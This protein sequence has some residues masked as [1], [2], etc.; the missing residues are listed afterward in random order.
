MKASLIYAL[1]AAGVILMGALP[2]RGYD[3]G[4]LCPVETVLVRREG[5]GLRLETDT[6]ALGLG[7]D[8]ES[9]MGDMEKRTGAVVFPGTV[10]HVIIEE[11]GLLPALLEER[12]LNPN[13]GVYL[14]ENITDP[15][16]AGTY[17]SAHRGGVS[18]GELRAGERPPRLKQQEG[19]FCLG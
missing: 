11:E 5:D 9:A 16:E 15:A 18:L 13:C 10:T 6:G 14:G 8:W 17:L 1:T 2:F 12:T 3:V 19:G 7:A 4:M